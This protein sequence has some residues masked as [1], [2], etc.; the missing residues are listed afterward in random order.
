MAQSTKT[1]SSNSRSNTRQKARGSSRSRS[2]TR[3]KARG[4]SRSTSAKRSNA[5]PSRSSSNGSRAKA[6]RASRSRSRAQSRSPQNRNGAGSITETAIDKARSS[7]RAVANAASKAKTPLI[8]GG[9][10]LLGAAGGAVIK[11]RLEGNSKK[12]PLKRLGSFK[13][14]A[15]VDLGKVDLDTVKTLATQ[16]KAYGQQASDIAEAVE[17]TRKKN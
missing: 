12:S 5:S 7:G 17:K 15:K 1:K 10:A 3:Q 4:S 11:S 14:M 16:M 9:T 2:N 6:P 8:A 13:P